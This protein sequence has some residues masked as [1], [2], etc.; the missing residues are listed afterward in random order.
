M[1]NNEGQQPASSA[2]L[3]SSAFSEIYDFARRAS[4]EESQEAIARHQRHLREL[5]GLREKAISAGDFKAAGVATILERMTSERLSIE[6]TNCERA[7][8]TG[9]QNC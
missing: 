8:P 3:S 5:A 2:A 4:Y 7:K 9:E 6:M 1:Q